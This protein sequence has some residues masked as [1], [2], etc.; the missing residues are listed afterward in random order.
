[1]IRRPDRLQHPYRY[2][3]PV[4][5]FSLARGAN[6]QKDPGIEVL[7][8]IRQIATDD[9][10][11]PQSWPLNIETRVRWW[12]RQFLHVL[13]DGAKCQP[14]RTLFHVCCSSITSMFHHYI[15]QFINLPFTALLR[16]Y[17]LPKNTIITKKI[18]RLTTNYRFHFF[19]II[20]SL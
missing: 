13:V 15:T 14:R 11:Q 9:I 5:G 10:L 4:L 3:V 19:S 8:S 20:L 1:M 16:S 12:G 2:P 18:V 7:S 17:K 6:D